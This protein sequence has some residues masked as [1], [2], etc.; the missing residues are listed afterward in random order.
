M[1][2]KFWLDTVFGTL[3]IF[4]VILFGMT[5]LSRMD[6]L[7]PMGEAIDDME[8]TDLVFSQLREE[9]LADTNIV[10]INIG[11]LP[12]ALFAEQIC[13]IN[14]Y[15]PKV[16][17][18]D[19]LYLQPKDPAGDSLLSAA[20]AEVDN[21]I[22]ASRLTT[23]NDDNNE[24]NLQT[25]H[26]LFDRHAKSA[27]ANLISDADEQYMFKVSR[28][29]TPR[30][31]LSEKEELAFGVK[32]AEVFD[33]EAAKVF[34]ARD[35]EYEV[36]NY[37]GNI[38]SNYNSGFNGK[39]YALD[40]EDVFNENFTPEIIKDKMVLFGYMG[41]N[42]N[43][44]SWEDKFF[45]PLNIDYAGKANPDMYGVVIHANIAAMIIN[46]DYV[47]AMGDTAGIIVGIILCYFNVFI[48]S[49]IH[50]RLPRWYDGISKL[51]QLLEVI[52]LLGV[53]VMVFY[54]FNYK[55][56][57]TLSI[58]AILLSGDTLEV[59][60]GIVKN[61]FTKAGRKELFKHREDDDDLT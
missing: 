53:I 46:G 49:I 58:I 18:I 2:K 30:E 19:A 21:L 48:F 39:F 38:L 37:R 36:I 33:P 8:V 12:R 60:Y 24:F 27:F 52:F 22:M 59:Y 51:T 50:R 26:D 28:T 15:Q 23:Y 35:K 7:D 29:F 1:D 55:L 31:N 9:P 43:D 11:N 34:L 10:V 54:W 16:I 56:N 3:F 14:K 17:G 42:F 25:S 44:M 32:V 40:V 61:S 41:Q 5:I 4:T 45:T 20:L 13:I 57:L 47:N 6:F